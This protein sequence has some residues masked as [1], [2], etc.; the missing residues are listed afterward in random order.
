MKTYFIS[1]FVALTYF[2]CTN[3]KKSDTTAFELNPRP[4]NYNRLL[5]RDNRQPVDFVE[6]A[7]KSINGVVH[8]KNTSIVS[9][10]FSYL[11]YFYGRNKNPQNRI[12]TGSGVV[13]SPDGYIITNNHVIEN[14]TKIEVTTN[15]NIRYEAKLVGTDPYT[16]IAVLKIETQ[17]LLPY[18]YF[19]DSDNTKIG[20]WVLAIGNPF[21]LNS[22]VTAGIISAK[23]RD[24]NK[25]DRR[26]QSFIQTDAAVNQG[27]SGGA[28]VNLNGE[29]IGINTAITTISGGFEGY[30]FAV[31]SNIARKVFED[32]I[33]F[34]TNQKGMLG[35]QG[36]A[37]SPEFEK[38]INENNIKQSEGFYV[39][40]VLENMGAY[41]AG[42]KEGD[43]LI[44]VDDIKIR[45]F[46]D[47]TGYLESKRPGDNV[48]IGFFRKDSKKYLNVKLEKTK[49]IQ[50]LNMTLSNLTKKEKDDLKIKSGIK[51]VESGEL[52]KGQIE[53]NSILIDVNGNSIDAVDQIL[54]I[55][56][57]NVRW[58]TYINPN[59]E[60]IRLRF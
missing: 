49:T 45:K 39:S 44:S 57:E 48:K 55:E 28:L 25:L 50:F 37:I 22:T 12:G 2:S 24:L 59:G 5:D 40:K 20:E 29:L 35:V 36:F 51:I 32:I 4:I 16:D 11:D 38:F 17:K 53:N 13:V 8:V 27:N 6:A 60:K 46:S 31:P 26:N 56:P 23:S 52:L 33:E 19:G 3:E 10:D 7:E 54:Q 9:D 18:L 1:W 21:N 41:N 47:L 43:V 30:S 34:G 58:I 14:A 42:I 15:E